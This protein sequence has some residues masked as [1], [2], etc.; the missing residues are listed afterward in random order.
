M[1][2][3]KKISRRQFIAGSA[4]AAAMFAGVE[5]IRHPG[6]VRAACALS[7]PLPYY[8]GIDE[9]VLKPEAVREYAFNHYFQGGCM[10]GAASGLMQ[11]FKEAFEGH[12]TGWDLIPYGMYQYGSAGVA[13]WGTLCGVLNGCLAIANLIDIHHLIAN[14]LMGWYTTTLFPM[15]SRSWPD[16][17]R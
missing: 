1:N 13:G 14:N 12:D 3:P 2:E 5:A 4:G 9:P 16:S 8:K 17:A 15:A 10:H 7:L 6:M 11:A